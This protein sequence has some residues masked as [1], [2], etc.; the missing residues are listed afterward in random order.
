MNGQVPMFLLKCIS[1]LEALTSIVSSDAKYRPAYE[2]NA[3]VGEHYLFV[4]ENTEIFGV[5]QMLATLL[6]THSE[7]F[8]TSCNITETEQATTKVM[9]QT[10]LSLAIVSIKVLNNVIRIDV[11]FVQEFMQ[12]CKIIQDHLFHLLNYLL[13]YSHENFDR[14][15]DTK[16]LLHETLMFIGYYCLLNEKTQQILHRGENTILQKLCNLPFPY[17]S[18]KKFK[19]ILFPTLIMASYKSERS[20]A[21]MN[22]EMSLDPLIRFLQYSMKEELPRIMEEEFD[23]QSIS[24]FGEPGKKNRGRGGA[25]SPSISSNTSSMCSVPIETL[26]SGNCPYLPLV[27]RFPK[28]KW[29]DAVEFYSKFNE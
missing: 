4:F 29:Q 5:V 6:L 27:M 23:Y 10:F 8:K 28:P 11:K 13:V 9:P 19:E 7:Q 2:R 24:S 14:C 1:F 12:G 16:E 18:D 15:E 20:V 3:K 26:A 25:R 21:I 22:Q 17:F